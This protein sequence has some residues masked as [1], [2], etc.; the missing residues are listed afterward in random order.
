MLA[1]S[2]P[3]EVLEIEVQEDSYLSRSM[4]TLDS[5]SKNT[6]TSPKRMYA[7][8]LFRYLFHVYILL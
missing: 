5:G 1:L 8:C 7:S 6:P 4:D 3:R 2:L